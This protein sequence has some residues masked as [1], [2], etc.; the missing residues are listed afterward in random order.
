MPRSFR[1]AF[2]IGQRLTSGFEA[3]GRAP[4]PLLLGAVLMQCTE[5]SGGS[6]S[7]GGGGDGGSW[8]E[9]DRLESYDWDSLGSHIGE[10]SGLASGGAIGQLGMGELAILVSIFLA[11]MGIVIGCAVVIVLFRAWLH[12]GYLRLRAEILRTG[13]GSFATLFGGADVFGSMLAYKVLSWVISMGVVLGALV[14]GIAVVIVGAVLESTPV[15]VVGLVMAALLSTPVSIYVW[16]GLRF[17]AHAVALDG[18][19]ALEALERS[20]ALARGHR[21]RML[22]YMV[23]TGALW[24]GGMCVC[25]VGI[26]VTRAVVDVAR[27][28]AYLL[29]TRDEPDLRSTRGW[30]G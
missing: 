8:D 26:F 27:T 19:G 20:W 9:A 11:V 10:L 13:S 21:L 3:L 14:P 18:D 6:Y 29:A 22:L 25:C 5:R 4:W 30:Q 2:D 16:L 15:A 1:D 7:G 23:V 12:P 17:G 28:E 24:L